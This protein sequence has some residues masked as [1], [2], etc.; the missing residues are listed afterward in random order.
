MAEGEIS[1]GGALSFAWSLLSHNWRALW[2]GLALNAL[3]WTVVFAGLFGS[4]PDLVTAGSVAMLV[5]KYPLYGAVFRL[6]AA[7]AGDAPDPKLGAMGLQ[8]RGMELRIFL[9]DLLVS[10]FSSLLFMLLLVAVAI[11]VGGV[12]LSRGGPPPLM[13]TPQQQLQALGPQGV[14]ILVGAYLVVAMILLFVATRLLLAFPA[15]ALSGKVAVLRTWRLTRGAFLRIFFAWFVLQAPVMLTL[16]LVV[17]GINGDLTAFTPAQILGY[18]VLS[19]ILAGAASVPL[20]A[21]VQLYFYKA[22]AAGADAK[23]EGR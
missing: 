17:S 15:S 14:D 16:T 11:V 10:A 3:S 19:G 2:G 5:T 8:W 13:S 18:S 21:A 7:P 20:T 22:L 12:L 23:A 9:A 1:I 6:G 4:R